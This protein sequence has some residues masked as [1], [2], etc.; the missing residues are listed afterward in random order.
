MTSAQVASIERP[1]LAIPVGS[2]EQHGPHLPLGTD[3]IIAESLCDVLASL[4]A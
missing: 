4:N 1:I 3:T 2:C